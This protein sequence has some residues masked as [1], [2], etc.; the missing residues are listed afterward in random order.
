M[1]NRIIIE[2]IPEDTM[3]L[4]NSLLEQ[5]S[6]ENPEFGTITAKLIVFLSNYKSGDV[7]PHEFWNFFQDLANVV[8]REPSGMLKF[9]QIQYEVMIIVNVFMKAGGLSITIPNK[10]TIQKKLSEAF[11]GLPSNHILE[12]AFLPPFLE[13]IGKNT[14]FS[15][16]LAIV[17]RG[18][19]NSSALIASQEGFEQSIELAESVALHAPIRLFESFWQNPEIIKHAK[20]LISL[21][22]SLSSGYIRFTL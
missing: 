6:V 12:G 15:G 14:D 8:G 19:T 22:W 1:S 16:F 9:T 3:N 17:R 5:A 18:M 2:N 20:D 13:F 10:E 21:N 7:I 11:T 4:L